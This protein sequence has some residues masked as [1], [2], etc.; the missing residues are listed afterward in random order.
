ML[1]WFDESHG[2]SFP[3]IHCTRTFR[4]FSVPTW[5]PLMLHFNR[6]RHHLNTIKQIQGSFTRRWLTGGL[7]LVGTNIAPVQT[8]AVG[9]PLQT[10]SFA[11]LATVQGGLNVTNR[12]N[13]GHH[14]GTVF[15]DGGVR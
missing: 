6:A 12:K 1:G 15:A 14:V 13:R 3:G 10:G 4:P 11:A 2:F 8:K 9:N 7:L 5:W